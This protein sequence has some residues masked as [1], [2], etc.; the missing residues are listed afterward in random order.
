VWPEDFA[1]SLGRRAGFVP[2]G[3]RSPDLRLTSEIV[4]ALVLMYVADG[5]TLPWEELWAKLRGELGIVIGVDT[6]EDR[7]ALEEVGVAQV[8]AEHLAKNAE[9]VLTAAVERGV[10]RRLPDSGAEAGGVCGDLH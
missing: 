5:Q 3:N 4:E 2:K 7:R 6:F 10:A 9:A 8:S 1:L